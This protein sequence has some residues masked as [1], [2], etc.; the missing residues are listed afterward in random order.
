MCRGWYGTLPTVIRRRPEGRAAVGWTRTA[1]LPAPGPI[2]TPSRSIVITSVHCR[3]CGYDLK[4]LPS[5]GRCSEC[6]LEVIETITHLVDPEASRLPRLRD[7]RGV[8]TGLLGVA[9]TY[10]LVASIVLLP[11][12]VPAL[13]ELG[14]AQLPTLDWPIPPRVVAS[15]VG[16]VG[17]WWLHL[18]LRSPAE[19]PVEDARRSTRWL[20]WGQVGWS[21]GVLAPMLGAWAG[22]HQR[23]PAALLETVPVPF[24]IA[25]LIGLRGL[26]QIVGL[27]SRAYRNA[28]GGRQS[29]D[30]LIGA[31]LTGTLGNVASAVG[32]WRGW[33]WLEIVGQTIFAVS[34]AL[35]LLGLLYL[36]VNCWWI[37][38]SLRKPPPRLDE[39]LRA[40]TAAQVREA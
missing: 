38:S 29:I 31:V 37:R 21:L 23:L 26:L 25:A 6:G 14:G 7:P 33:V 10:L 22:V 24:A 11:R 3:R 12:A 5:S 27:R 8:G 36:I 32:T 15:A 2:A 30:A 40:T 18:L 28:Q 1:L 35:L 16:L 39:L 4:G 13:M 19:A 17:L 9:M 20:I 34:A